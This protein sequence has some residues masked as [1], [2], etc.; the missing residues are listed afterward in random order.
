MLKS[1]CTQNNNDCATCSLVN[2]GLDCANNPLPQVIQL[3][4]EYYD[5]VK[6]LT[7]ISRFHRTFETIWDGIPEI[8]KEQLSPDQLSLVV[9]TKAQS[10]AD[11]KASAGAEMIDSNCVWINGLN[12]AIEWTEEGAEYQQPETTVEGNTQITR[13]VK[14]KDGVLVPRFAD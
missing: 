3:Q 6:A 1:Y 12:R 13:Q 11:G 4:T 5:R 9:D 2:Y 8:L 10:F 7:N 14:I